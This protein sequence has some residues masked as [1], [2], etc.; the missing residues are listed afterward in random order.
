M[1]V[2][3]VFVPVS[4]T[5]TPAPSKVGLTVPVALHVDAEAEVTDRGKLC[6]I[7]FALATKVALWVTVTAGALAVNPIL[8]AV[9]GTVTELGSVT[10][11]PAGSVLIRLT[12]T[13]PIGAAA[14]N[15]TVHEEEPGPTMDDG[16]Q[17]SPLTP[18]SVVVAGLIWRVSALETPLALALRVAECVVVTVVALAVNPT[19]LA[20]AG[21]LMEAGTVATGSLLVRPTLNPPVGAAPVSVTAQ[22]AE[23]GLAIVVGLHEIALSADVCD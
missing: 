10:T 11:F 22:A 5:L 20:P 13:P 3:A 9:A 18:G 1:V 17:E 14:F 6:F 19:L 23:P 21:T 4:E 8:V 12:S 2:I 15:V 16:V 7:P